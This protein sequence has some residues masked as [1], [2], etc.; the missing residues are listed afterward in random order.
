M[1]TTKQ[2]IDDLE[3]RINALKADAEKPPLSLFGRLRHD[4]GEGPTCRVWDQPGALIKYRALTI[5][6]SFGAIQG[7][8]PVTGQGPTIPGSGPEEV[9]RPCL[10]C[11]HWR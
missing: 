4:G 10:T 8:C 5:R 6:G 1:T 2:L 9:Q 11:K 3:R 7:G